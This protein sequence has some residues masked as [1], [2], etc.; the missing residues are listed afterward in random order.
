MAPS[1]QTKTHSTAVAPETIEDLREA[2]AQLAATLD[3]LPDL[4]FE[5]DLTGRIFEFRAPHPELLF[6]P[7]EHFLGKR[8]CEV[9]PK[10]AADIVMGAIEE[11]DKKGRHR[12]AIYQLDT[13]QGPGWFE[14]SIA[15]KEATRARPDRRFVALV[16]D[17]TDRIKIDE[18]LRRSEI[19]YRTIFE[20]TGTATVIFDNDGIITL[21]S[22]EFI[23]LTG[24]TKDEIEGKLTWMDVVDREQLER[25]QRYHELRGRDPNA[26]PRRYEARIRSKNGKMHDGVLAVDLIPGT[27]ERVVSFLDLT[28]LKQAQE[29][30]FRAEKMAALGQIVAGV[31]HE[32]NNP[33]NFIYF[34]LP[35]LRRYVEAIREHL[36]ADASSGSV[37]TV[38]DQ[39][40]EV[41]ID[42]LFKLLE[43]MEHGSKRIT[44]IV[45]E[46]KAYVRCNEDEMRP[47]RIEV[48]VNRVMTL[49]GK[50]V[51]KM[52]KRFDVEIAPGLPPLDMN[53]GKI[54]QVL[55]NLL[56][57]AGQAADKDDSWVKLT[58]RRHERRPNVV[59]LTVEDNGAGIPKE[60]LHRVF[61]PFYTSKSREEGTGLGLS[62]SQ[63]IVEEHGGRIG[64]TSTEGNGALFT[65]ELPAR[66]DA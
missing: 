57:N 56:L 48:V 17:V 32:I 20:T 50:Q 45:E 46:L 22:T 5:V 61:E 65:V 37:R 36:D 16:H 55:V 63:R 40:Y 14:L 13:P 21:A 10:P 4:L 11:T 25:M 34:N 26:A 51:R 27:T 58:V 2:Q 7:P 18:A 1:P 39:P 28:E 3:A 24:Y 33:N 59:T 53:A 47:E 44:A 42:D 19:R 29:Q 9:L 62:I 35:I 38:L 6:A 12:G 41:F 30:M 8:I 49:V 43:N 64:V 54:E 60:A 66:R 52:V 31:A 15:V 23:E